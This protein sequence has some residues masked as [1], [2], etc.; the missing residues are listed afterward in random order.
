M[1][2]PE[3]ESASYE[4][5]DRRQKCPDCGHDTRWH[6]VEGCMLPACQCRK[7]CKPKEAA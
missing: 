2:G 5:A 6:C 7:D 1:S 4:G 3:V